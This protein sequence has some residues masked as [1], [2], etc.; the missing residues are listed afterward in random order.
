MKLV[1]PEF[2][3]EA[4][5]AE[6]GEDMADSGHDIG[7]GVGP[8]DTVVHEGPRGEV[9]GIDHPLEGGGDVCQLKR[10]DSPLVQEDCLVAILSRH[11]DQVECRVDVETDIVPVARHERHQFGD[12]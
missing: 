1:F 3:P 8:H 11:R 10:H 4:G 12:R 5:S 9:N 6:E 2:H 7:V